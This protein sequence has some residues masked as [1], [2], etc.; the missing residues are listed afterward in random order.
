MSDET[1]IQL[2][3]HHDLAML[4]KVFQR[5]GRMHIP[6]IFTP[7]TALRIGQCLRYETP[8]FYTFNRERKAENLSK[9]EWEALSEEELGG[10]SHH[11]LDSAGRGFQFFYNNYRME[12]EH[13]Q[14][15]WPDLFLNKVLAYL[16][17]KP[18][19]TFARAVT[20]L[21]NIAEVDA[22][23]TLYRGGHFLTQHDDDQPGQKRLAAYVLN[24][25]PNWN[26]DWGGILNFIDADGHIAEGYAPA[27]NALN[28]FKVP[29]L[30]AVSMV[31][32]FAREGRY[33]I[34]GWMKYR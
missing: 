32:P 23:A 22:Q 16:N 20:G 2:S 14:R 31:T 9:A 3:P 33:S 7:E 5:T 25:T 24:F 12:N 11:I 4:A 17:S 19:L 6:D 28:V 1:E 26:T 10:I 15:D 34:T 27:F 8:W 29:Q 21:K 13:N 18:F 30:H